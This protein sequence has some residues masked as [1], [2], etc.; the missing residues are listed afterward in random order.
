MEKTLNSHT[1][2]PKGHM[3]PFSNQIENWYETYYLDLLNKRISIRD[4]KDVNVIRGYYD[5]QTEKSLNDLIECRFFNLRDEMI[6]MIEG[7]KAINFDIKKHRIVINYIDVLFLRSKFAIN[8]YNKNSLISP[9]FGN[10]SH[11][12]FIKFR[13]MNIENNLMFKNYRIL[14]IAN[15][16]NANFVLPA[17]GFIAT[18]SL[19]SE[20]N[21]S[22]GLHFI[23]PITPKLA[24]LLIDKNDYKLYLEIHDNSINLNI[25]KEVDIFYINQ[26]AYKFEVKMNNKFLV[27]KTRDELIRLLTNIC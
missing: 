3:K 12:D 26:Y 5:N 19:Y 25:E 17:F 6:K 13:L 10:M 1:Q 7:K 2:L 23:L 27:S 11:N 22:G 8:G 9:V 18:Q 4:I 24:Y 21:D 15:K 20:I 14:T 16:T